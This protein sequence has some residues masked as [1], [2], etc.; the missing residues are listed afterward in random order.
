MRVGG[1]FVW[2]PPSPSLVLKDGDVDSKAQQQK[3]QRVV[4]IAGGVGINPLMSMLSHITELKATLNVQS[5]ARSHDAENV[6]GKLGFKIVFL[7]S[8]KHVPA[9]DGEILFLSRLKQCFDIL[10]EEGELRLFLTGKATLPA[11]RE[12]G[13]AA[14]HS[15]GDVR[16]Q[17]RRITPDDVRDVLGPVAER[18]G[19][20]FYACGVPTMTDTFV[21]VAEMAEGM[22]A[23]NVLCE[24]WW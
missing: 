21:K 6:D 19:T 18:G 14:Q 5:K 8:S 9:T 17:E 10:G 24:R 1:S 20:V 16:I 12:L 23:E 2:P 11:D 13:Q 4:F 15:T 3:L 22:R 7:Y